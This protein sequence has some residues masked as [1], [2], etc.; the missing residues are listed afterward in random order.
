MIAKAAQALTAGKFL[1][2][3]IPIPA[4]LQ[5]TAGY[6]GDG[7]AQK[8]LE[9]KNEANIEKHGYANWYDFCVEEWGTKW[10]VSCY[11]EVAISDDGNSLEAGF[12]SAWGPPIG[13]Y[14]KLEELGFTVEAMY[15][16]PGCAFCGQW[17]DGFDEQYNIPDNADAVKE[18]IP[19]RIDEAFGISENVADFEEEDIE[20]YVES[21]GE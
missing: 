7:D 2:T 20:P 16:E 8:E 11:S 6:L 10:D 19:T 5:I 3:F 18:E 12:E 9:A 14:P 21:F 17:V 4:D 1:E 13:A 15:Y